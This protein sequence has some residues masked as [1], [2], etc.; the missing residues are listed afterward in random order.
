MAVAKRVAE[1]E[2]QLAKTRAERDELLRDVETLCMQVPATLGVS[3][4]RHIACAGNM[5]MHGCTC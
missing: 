1:L 4:E 2:A 5:F 3:I